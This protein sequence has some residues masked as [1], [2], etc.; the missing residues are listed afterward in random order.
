VV[1]A[2]KMHPDQVDTDA[3]LVRALLGDQHPGWSVLPIE[4]VR[5]AGTD[6]DIYR[7]GDDL[8][9][10][11]PR[12]AWATGQAAKEAVWLPRL[13][14][15]LPLAL[16]VQLATGR[17]GHGYPFRW[18]VYRW[19]PGRSASD[20]SVDRDDVAEDLAAFITA[21][22]AVPIDGAPARPVGSRGGPLSEHDNDVRT[23]L[24][25]LDR[26]VRQGGLE[27]AASGEDLD[28]SAVLH[29]WQRALA[30]PV[31]H[32]R[33]VWLHGDLLPGN[34]LLT[35]G[36]LSAVIDWG[37]LGVG[38]PACDLQPAWHLFSGTRRQHFRELL[39]VDDASWARGRGT[40]IYQTVMAFPYYWRTNPGIV[41][42]SWRAL[43]AVLAEDGR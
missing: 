1:A 20:V 11:L 41:K 36:A 23:A 26:L 24:D 19:L 42:Q 3:D 25:Q 27:G 37:G 38:D 4:Q 17:P 40:V 10:R 6:H 15:H 14:P 33:P 29:A 18:S 12:T 28:T 9:A 22:R 32:G 39:N 31:W 16:P 2:S 43:N 13:A 34:I 35:A 5:S 30:A 7:V 8:A 21:L